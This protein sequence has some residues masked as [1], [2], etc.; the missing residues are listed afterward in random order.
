MDTFRR[1]GPPRASAPAH[2]LHHPTPETP[3]ASRV[4]CVH[5]TP[6]PAGSATPPPPNA[7]H[8]T[9]YDAPR[10]VSVGGGLAEA[11]TGPTG[12]A[13]M[14]RCVHATRPSAGSATPLIVG[15]ALAATPRVER[16]T[17]LR[18]QNHTLLASWDLTSMQRYSV[19]KARRA[20]K[21]QPYIG[22]QSRCLLRVRPSRFRDFALNPNPSA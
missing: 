18:N 2:P 13:S 11:A 20:R 10:H 17:A 7:D 15:L 22:M 3:C 16:S 21:G 9:H 14:I 4:R 6:I 1:L 12:P 19:C 5:A 8:G